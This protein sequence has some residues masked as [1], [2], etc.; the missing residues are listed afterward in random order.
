M[1]V[2]LCE[3]SLEG[4]FTGIY[5]AYALRVPLWEVRLQAGCEEELRLFA[6]Y[7]EV[8]PDEE[9]TQKV[10][11][12]LKER[13]G[14]RDYHALCMALSSEDTEKAEAVFRAVVWGLS[15]KRR[16]SILEH[17]TDDNIRKVL[18]LSR[19]ANN[20]T[21]H[22]RGFVRFQELD[23]GILYAA[24]APKNNVLPYLGEHFA[25]RLPM[26]NFLIADEKRG[27]YLV[28][29]AGKEWF[30]YRADAGEEEKGGNAGGMA[31]VE[32][33]LSAD[34]QIYQELFRQF[35]HTI[36]IES[37]K[38]LN[39]QRNMLPMRFRP[40]MVEFFEK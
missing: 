32:G 17:L 28:H 39:L 14:A 1:L 21:Q 36:S 22:L 27:L 37:R 4:I 10:I 15:Q 30:L 29:P 38:N 34:E 18:E 5:E 19:G 24:V 2:L 13:F 26:E 31:S 8:R 11:R 3:D 6:T 23:G 20:E 25:D 7:R 16:G 35:C 33:K 12:T 40:Y 9:K